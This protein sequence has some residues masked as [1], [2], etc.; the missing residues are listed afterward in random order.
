MWRFAAAHS[1]CVRCRLDQGIFHGGGSC[2]PASLFRDISSLERSA[3][4]GVAGGLGDLLPKSAFGDDRLS[5]AGDSLFL[6]GFLAGRCRGFRAASGGT[7]AADL[8]FFDLQT[9]LVLR[10]T[11]LLHVRNVLW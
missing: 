6:F 5:R 8:V 1:G 9:G 7:G 3:A 2:L 11:F 10:E 4:A